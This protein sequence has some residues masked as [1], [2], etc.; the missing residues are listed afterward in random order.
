MATHSLFVKKA[1]GLK[2]GVGIKYLTMGDIVSLVAVGKA[3]R[4]PRWEHRVGRLIQLRR[5]R[6]NRVAREKLRDQAETICILCGN[7]T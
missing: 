2:C 7:P 3:S 5:A 1:L 6:E 4:F